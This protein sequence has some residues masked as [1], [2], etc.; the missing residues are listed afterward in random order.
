[1]R[2]TIVRHGET[3]SNKDDLLQGQLGGELNEIGIKQ[4]INLRDYLSQSTFDLIISSDLN[5]CKQTAIIIAEKQTC[6]TDYN[7][8]IRERSFGVFQGKSRTDF[9]KNERALSNPYTNTPESGESITNLYTR[10]EKFISNLIIQKKYTNILVVCH[11]DTTRMLLG[12]MQCFDIEKSAKIPLKNACES[13]VSYID[14]QFKIIKIN[15]VEH[16]DE[17]YLSENLSEL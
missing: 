9:F 7:K 16:L 12:V 6:L 10:A 3:T 17:M 11:G 15:S 1:M 13:V 4:S 8:L 14:K 5:R 2:I